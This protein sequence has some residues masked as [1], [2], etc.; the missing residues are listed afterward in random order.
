MGKLARIVTGV[1][2]ARHI[3]VGAKR[4]YGSKISKGEFIKVT[5]GLTELMQQGDRVR[6]LF[7]EPKERKDLQFGS[8]EFKMVPRVITRSI[9]ALTCLESDQQPNALVIEDSFLFPTVIYMP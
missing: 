8:K 1:F 2:E 3:H 4:C 6:Y 9:L 7:G 5:I